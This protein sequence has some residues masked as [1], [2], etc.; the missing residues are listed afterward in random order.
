MSGRPGSG[1]RPIGTAAGGVPPGTSAR[2]GSGRRPPGTGRLKTGVM[3][4][5]RN[6]LSHYFHYLLL[7]LFLS[8]SLLPSLCLGVAT[9]AGTQAATGFALN[10]SVNVS[11]RP[12]TGQGMMGMKLHG[13]G[14]G[15]NHR[16]YHLY[17]LLSSSDSA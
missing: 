15:G 17:S 3:P 5:T 8:L 13:Q 14:G 9:G 7:T 10:A 6:T 2:P 4:L 16:P 12:V 11:D 1:Q